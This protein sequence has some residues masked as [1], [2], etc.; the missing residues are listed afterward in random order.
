MTQF[1]PV[2][3][4]NEAD[5]LGATTFKRG[6]AEEVYYET[7]TISGESVAGGMTD[8]GPIRLSADPLVEEGIAFLQQPGRA[9][10]KLP[11]AGYWFLVAMAAASAF[12]IS[13][14]HVLFSR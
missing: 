12:W 9:Q 10:G 11:G 13:G 7:V 8:R 6:V 14:G 3:G 1:R 5:F 2:I 4:E